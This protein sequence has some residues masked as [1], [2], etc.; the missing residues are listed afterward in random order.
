MPP[1]SCA[2]IVD[3]YGDDF[4]K[5]P[6]QI[7]SNMFK[8]NQECAEKNNNYQNKIK[9][10]EIAGKHEYS[11]ING[12]NI[13]IPTNV[14][15]RM[16]W[17]NSINS[18]QDKLGNSFLNRFQKPGIEYFSDSEHLMELL[19]EGVFLLKIII[20]VLILILISNFTK[21]N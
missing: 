15:P 21:K 9:T 11:N 8:K 18:F 12:Q 17:N 16:A 14:A 5:S 7:A 10:E 19:V 13:P 2:S 6:E 3:H 4:G 1:L 20:F